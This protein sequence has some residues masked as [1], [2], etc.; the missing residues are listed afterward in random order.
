VSRFKSG[1]PTDSAV[2]RA[3][4]GWHGERGRDLLPGAERLGAFDVEAQ[5][6]GN[7]R[8]VVLA[9][10]RPVAIGLMRHSSGERVIRAKGAQ[11]KYQTVSD[12]R[13]GRCTDMAG[14]EAGD[15]RLLLAA[16]GRPRVGPLD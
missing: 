5:A 6:L 2:W 14:R 4:H 10:A 15:P 13:P 3:W 12:G 11:A 1:T 16:L 9:T 8:R 7:E